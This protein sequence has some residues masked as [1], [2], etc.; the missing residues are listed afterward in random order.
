MF[1]FYEQPWTLLGIAVIVLFGIL[2]YRSVVPEKKRAWQ[3][4][5]PL[6]IALAGFGIDR[7]V[8]TDTEKI[9]SIIDSGI[10]AVKAENFNAVDSYISDDY[11]DSFHRS[12]EQLISHVQSRRNK[13]NI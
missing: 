9:N 7:L 1:N 4:L 3:L 6:L 10:K 12:K 8:T 5:I 13:T 11:R 2:T